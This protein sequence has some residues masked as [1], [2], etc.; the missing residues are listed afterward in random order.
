MNFTDALRLIESESGDCVFIDLEVTPGAKSSEIPS[1]YNP[2]RKRIEVRIS[3]QAQKGK[4]NEQL[5]E[6]FSKF[7]SVPKS[8]IKV[9]SGFTSTKKTLSVCSVTLE[10]VEKKFK[11]AF[12]K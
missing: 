4:A 10:F 5:I 12:E 3:E 11:D 6:D 7:L 2:W 9:E 1:G 8:S